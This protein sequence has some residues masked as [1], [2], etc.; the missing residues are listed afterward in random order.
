[1]TWIR[2]LF[3]RQAAPDEVEVPVAA[4]AAAM[5]AFARC[6]GVLSLA[7]FASLPEEAREALAAAHREIRA[8]TIAALVR[9]TQGAEGLLDVLRHVG[10]GTAAEEGRATIA[11]HQALAAAF[12]RRVP[13]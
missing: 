2:R 6:G 8:E 11:A 10:D 7:E 1:M 13:L 3:R 5:R 12:A 4:L 9:A